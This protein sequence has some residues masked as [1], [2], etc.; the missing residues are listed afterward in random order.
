M[1]K[2]K[3]IWIAVFCFYLF[4]LNLAVA[5]TDAD[6]LNRLE[7]EI[8]LLKSDQEKA[9][10]LTKNS[11][12]VFAK[13]NMRFYGRV[14]VDFN[15]D[16]AEFRRYNDFIGAVGAGKDAKNDSVNF[17]CRDIRF[18]I[19][20]SHTDDNFTVKGRFETD[21]YGDN[22]GDNLIPRLR[23]G[24]VDLI[25]N[26][27][28]TSLRIG[29]DWIPVAQQNPDT[30]DFGILST[31]GNLWWRVPQITMRQKAGDLEF[32]LSAMKHRR[33]D[34]NETDRMPWVLGRIAYNF[35]K[36][37]NLIAV[38][39]GYR[40]N[41]DYN[42]TGKEITRSLAALEFKCFMGPVL[43]KAEGFWGKGIDNEFLRYDM[44]VNIS[45]PDNPDEIE[46]IGGFISF[47]ADIFDKI[48][49]STGYG[50]DD[51]EDDDMDGMQGYLNDRQFTKNS[52]AFLNSWYKL[53]KAVKI[54]AE[55]IYVETE[56]FSSTNY[57][58]RSTLSVFYNF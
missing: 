44:G 37:D 53:T 13:Y 57:G 15:Y 50:I 31:S 48:T 19:E 22:N 18:G 45:D 33:K 23:V 42:N 56:R 14:K 32:L 58:L 25:K 4:T 49:L 12:N 6:R 28:N 27:T 40:K 16:T 47:S 41:S 5:E 11:S 3:L 21:F 29:Q 10:D 38:G 39:G 43:V 34:T 35:G 52:M 54:G 9:Q 8:L 46:S 51:P 26:S 7:K 1:K 17:N 36:D 55:V 2:W 24:Y 30:I 20:A